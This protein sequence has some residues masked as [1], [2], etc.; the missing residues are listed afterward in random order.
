MNSLNMH[1][2]HLKPTE[3][4]AIYYNV[5]NLLM[6]TMRMLVKFTTQLDPMILTRVLL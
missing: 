5:R 2:L 4:Q 3:E 1:H 6:I